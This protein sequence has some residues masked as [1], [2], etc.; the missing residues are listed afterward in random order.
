[1]HTDKHEG[2]L[3][4]LSLP[5]TLAGIEDD[6]RVRRGACKGPAGKSELQTA[7]A[8]S[9]DVQ[10]G[11]QKR[12]GGV[13]ELTAGTGRRHDAPG[14]CSNITTPPSTAPDPVIPVSKGASGKGKA[15][16]RPRE[17]AKRAT[18]GRS[19]TAAKKTKGQ[20]Q[21][22]PKYTLSEYAKMLQ[23]QATAQPQQGGKRKLPQFLKGRRIYFYGGDFNFV[24]QS[25]RSK[26]QL[27]S[28]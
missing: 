3:A 9:S 25:T 6:A 4:D 5:A 18:A 26:M 7:S 14:D 22:E 23:A 21:K 12:T 20:K 11:G 10:R 1:M 8:S 27:V 16:A 28:G 24:G 15:A 2:R 19:S 13:R 17:P